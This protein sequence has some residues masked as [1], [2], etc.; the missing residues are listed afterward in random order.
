MKYKANQRELKKRMRCL[1]LGYCDHQKVFRLLE[2]NAYTCGT[3]GW[4]ADIYEVGGNFAIVTGYRPFG[5]ARFNLT[6]YEL[7]EIESIEQ[8]YLMGNIR[9]GERDGKVKDVLRD[10]CDRCWEEAGL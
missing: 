7:D 3:Y 6:E 2:P 8:D 10:A 4:N 1:S 9:H 5:D